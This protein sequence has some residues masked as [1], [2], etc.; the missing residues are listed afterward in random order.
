MKATEEKYESI[1]LTFRRVRNA[2]LPA[3]L[4]AVPSGGNLITE[5]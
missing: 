1:Q 5:A 4:H 2:V 3:G